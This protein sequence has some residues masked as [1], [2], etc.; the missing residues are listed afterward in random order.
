MLAS[1]LGIRSAANVPLV[2]L[3]AG[4]AGIRS[5]WNVPA[6]TLLA[7]RLGI[8]ASLSVPLD[9]LLALMLVMPLPL[10]DSV[11][12]MVV[13]VKAPST[14]QP[15]LSPFKRGAPCVTLKR[16]APPADCTDRI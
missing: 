4:R 9:M 7:L 15:A 13:A 14:L 5:T 6:V 8:R 11:P 12:L 16:S 1:R 2:I 10:P 3:L